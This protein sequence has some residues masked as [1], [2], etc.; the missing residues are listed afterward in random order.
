RAGRLNPFGLD[1]RRFLLAVTSSGDIVGCVQ[2]RPH[3]GGARELASLYVRP[4]WRRRG[5]GA[6][7]VQAI[8][9]RESPPL[10]LTCRSELVPF[11][12]RFGFEPVE[13]MD[14]MPTYFRLV[15]WMFG[16]VRRLTRTNRELV[17]MS[18]R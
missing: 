17:V 13:R 1:W 11:Y 14:E 6:R 15:W 18:W 7:L 4:E 9:E 16:L 5:V 12:R 10:W 2:T 8:L 3:R